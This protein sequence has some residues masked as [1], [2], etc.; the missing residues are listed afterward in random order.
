ML[1]ILFP[2]H[3]NDR[4][5]TIWLSGA[6]NPGEHTSTHLIIDWEAIYY[7]IREICHHLASSLPDKV[8]ANAFP[9]TT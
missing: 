4:I 7:Y 8:Y 2:L 9:Y 1:T 6:S 3:P 5:L